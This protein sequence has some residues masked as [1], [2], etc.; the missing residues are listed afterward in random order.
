VAVSVAVPVGGGVSEGVAPMDCEGDDEPVPD[1]EGT[2]VA[3]ANA[4]L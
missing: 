3:Y 4:T 1:G 2:G